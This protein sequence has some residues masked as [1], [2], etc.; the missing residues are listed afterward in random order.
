MR[1]RLLLDTCAAI[2]MSENA[3]IRQAAMEAMGSAY[4]NGED[5]A[6]SPISAWERGLLAA[7]GRLAS[8]L[9]PYK[10]FIEVAKT[11]GMTVL[12]L[13]PEILIDSSFLPG[14]I[15]GDP[16]D[17]IIIATA[18][19]HDLTVVTRDRHILAYAAAGHVRALEC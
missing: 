4:E 5:V 11:P 19:A 9:S 8:P 7:K 3:K 14:P 10:W 1:T 12:P 15:H 18:R 16:A 2:W 13:T 17:R 6:V